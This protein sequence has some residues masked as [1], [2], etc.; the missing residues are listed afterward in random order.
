MEKSLGH[1]LCEKIICYLHERAVDFE[2]RAHSPATTCEESA[3]KRKLPLQ[4]GLKSVLFKSKDSFV[5]FSLRSHLKVNSNKVRK[6]LSCQRLRFAT[7]Q[8]LKQLAQVP[9]GGLPPFG[10]PLLPFKHYLDSSI[11]EYAEVAFNPG[12]LDQSII[13]KTKTYLSLVAPVRTDFSQ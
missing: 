11:D 12:V 7:D 3:L 5:L 1:N 10:P 8:E 13:L 2:V 4:A 9:K 6:I